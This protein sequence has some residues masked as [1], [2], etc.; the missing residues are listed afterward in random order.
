MMQR[1]L[2][3]LWMRRL[4]LAIFGLSGSLGRSVTPCRMVV[5]F[6]TRFLT[7]GLEL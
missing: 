1:C 5:H 6:G 3:A 7:F 2:M 4:S